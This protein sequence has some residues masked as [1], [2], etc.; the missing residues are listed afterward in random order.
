[1]S[2]N[3]HYP[4]LMT[5]LD[6]G[7]TTLKNRVIMGS[8]HVG[9]EDRI[10]HFNELSAYFAERAR[11]GVGLIVT[12]GFSPNRAGDLLPF[13]SKL[14]HSWQIPFHGSIT[15]AVHKAGSKILLQIL[16]AGRYG[17]T[18]FNVA[19][20]AIKA[21][22]SPFTPKALTSRA[23]TKTIADYVR[24][25][26]LAQRAG[27]DGVEI[28][29]S[30]GYLICQMLNARTNER[31][32]EWGGSYENRMRF[33]LEIVRQIRAAVGENFIVMFRLSMLDLVE[34]GSTMDEVITLAKRL[35]QCGVTLLN[36][37]IGWH[38]ARIPTIVTSVPRGAFTEVTAQ[39]KQAVSI[40]VVA[41]N[42]INMP[43][44]AEQILTSGVA[45]MVSMARPFLADPEWVNKAAQGRA[46]EINTCIA[47]NQACLDHVFDR[48]RASCLVNP[49]AA[50]ELRLRYQPVDHAKK[51]AVV[52]AGP[53]GLAC[54]T[55]AAQRGHKVTLFEAS[56][57]IGG[58]FNYASR[59]PGKEEFRET[60]RYFV[61]QLTIH[62]VN[63]QLNYRATAEQLRAGNFDQI[64][65]AS[66]VVPR[67]PRIPGIDHAKVMTYQQVLKGHKVLGERVAIMGAGG[68]GFDMCEYVVHDGDSEALDKQTWMREWG[69]DGTNRSR[70]GLCP[71][72]IAPSARK[73][74]M[75]Q[76]KQTRFGQGLNK[77]SGWVHRASIKMKGVET[78]GGVSYDK[79]DDEG[80]HI[81]IRSG[82]GEH[83]TEQ[84]RV[85]DV[86]HIILCTGQVSENALYQELA[87]DQFSLF[88][89]HLVG[90]AE[91]AGELDA[92]RAIRLA[93]ELAAAL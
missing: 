57:E 28:M 19:P 59:I 65:I 79:V 20:S 40:P 90:G 21:P 14:I 53:A 41:S 32:D 83:Q 54:A 2:A 43:E 49:R 27:Y 46:D 16:H 10:W 26:K 63:L 67:V 45:D 61:K 12:G 37:G 77:T 38:E 72:E 3:P 34:N 50:H 78:I 69:V 31:T 17:Y 35:E 91:F 4:Q 73:V 22:I 11:G 29:G 86:D 55:V 92:K 74:Y 6:L 15:R 71:P 81:T 25:A 87:D 76:R 80:L 36:T 82:K 44:Q 1:M 30:E 62:R 75:L 64:V 89:L 13:G 70:G 52:G 93:S 60:I 24:C 58:Q 51:I 56:G 5:P 47:C 39:V 48:R 68:I 66:G 7:F 8:M 23:I 9:L 42:R 33:A 84:K 88:G 85:L 18:P